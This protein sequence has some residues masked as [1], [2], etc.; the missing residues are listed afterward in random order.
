MP[1]Y[2]LSCLLLLLAFAIAT[3]GKADTSIPSKE[4]ISELLN[5]ADQKISTF[6]DAVK[7]CKAGSG[8]CCS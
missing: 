3:P 7:K 5:K 2:S 4:E 8:N 1:G 6:E